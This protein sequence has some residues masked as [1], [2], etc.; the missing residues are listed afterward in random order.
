MVFPYFFIDFLRFELYIM[1]GLCIALPCGEMRESVKS[2]A[3]SEIGPETTRHGV[4]PLRHAVGGAGQFRL[5]ESSV[6]GQPPAQ[7]AP[8]TD[9]LPFLLRP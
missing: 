6:P 7:T 8:E 4:A 2:D 9:R 3:D 1:V 5:Y